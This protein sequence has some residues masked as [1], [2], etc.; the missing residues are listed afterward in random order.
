MSTESKA[1]I[2]LTTAAIC[3]SEQVRAAVPLGDGDRPPDAFDAYEGARSHLAEVALAYARD[4]GDLTADE[5]AEL[6]ALRRFRDGVKALR[7]E[8]AAGRTDEG[9]AITEPREHAVETIDAFLALSCPP[10]PGARAVK[11]VA[12]LLEEIR[13]RALDQRREGRE[14][15]VALH[16]A[17][18]QRVVLELGAR[19]DADVIAGMRITLH[20]PEG[21]VIVRPDPDAPLDCVH[22]TPAVLP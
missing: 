13:A 16:P 18:F 4:A 14:P 3:F 7:S 21:P 19:V 20:V 8:M 6:L 22:A 9:E 11:P 1:M 5:R 12:E 15:A 17:T 2:H 10:V